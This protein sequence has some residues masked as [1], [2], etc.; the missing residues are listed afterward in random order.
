MYDCKNV[1]ISLLLI[2]SENYS[3]TNQPREEKIQ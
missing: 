3:I 1:F 2:I